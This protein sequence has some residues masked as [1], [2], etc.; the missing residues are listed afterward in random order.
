MAE[1]SGFVLIDLP[2]HARRLIYLFNCL[3]LEFPILGM[4]TPRSTF[5]A[6]GILTAKAMGTRT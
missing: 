1:P 5:R 6:K 3:Y 2:S 4:H